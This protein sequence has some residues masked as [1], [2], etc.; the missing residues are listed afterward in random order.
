MQLMSFNITI[1]AR[2]F[3]KYL[4]YVFRTIIISIPV[5]IL[6]M[7]T[8]PRAV[9]TCINSL[10]ATFTLTVDICLPAIFWLMS[11]KIAGFLRCLPGFHEG[12]DCHPIF[13]VLIL[14]GCTHAHL[15]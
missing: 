14:G 7:Q 5:I 1:A 8:I 2:N 13:I 10:T 9:C 15:D 6:R 3:P 12:L 11:Q 4:V